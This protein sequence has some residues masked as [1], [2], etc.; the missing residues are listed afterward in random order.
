VSTPE[1]ITQRDQRWR[2]RH[3]E[4]VADAVQSNDPATIRRLYK[5]LG[6]FLEESFGDDV[7]GVPQLSLPETVPVVTGL[8]GGIGGRLLD[9]GCGPHPVASIMLARA[10]P[11][12]AIVGLDLG[13][14]TVRLARATAERVGVRLLA[15]V[16]DL[17]RLP[18]RDAAFAGIVCDDTIEHVPDDQRGVAEL[19]RVVPRGGVIVLATPNRHSLEVVVHRLRDRLRGHRQPAS[20][21]FAAESHLREYT[22]PE[23]A[24]LVAPFATVEER[25]TVGWSGGRRRRLASRLT[26]LPGFRHTGRMLVARLT[27]R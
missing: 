25:A 13:L 7:A 6:Q 15:V 4:Q 10:E 16:A 24:R 21:Y 22:W 2:A 23:F 12:R 8:L 17:E 19:C 11:G 26:G 1:D 20:A 14:G 5:D 3:G 18:F 9:A 27:P